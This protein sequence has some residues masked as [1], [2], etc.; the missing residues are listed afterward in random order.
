MKGTIDTPNKQA[1]TRSHRHK[2]PTITPQ[3]LALVSWFRNLPHAAQLAL[4]EKAKQPK[5]PVG[6]AGLEQ[7][8]VE[9]G[10]ELQRKGLAVNSQRLYLTDLATF[11]RFLT[12][13]ERDVTE[14][15][16]PL[17]QQYCAYLTDR[18]Y[19]RASVSRQLTALHGFVM[20]LRREGVLDMAQIP[21]P[22]MFI[23]KV[24][25]SI[26][27]HLNM[28]E[29]NRLIEAPDNITPYGIRDRAILEF[30][31]GAGVRVSELV[32]LDIGDL[33]LHC[34]LS[35]ARPE[36][37]QGRDT[38]ALFLSR[39]GDRITVRTVEKLVQG[40]ARQVNIDRRVYPHLLR[41]SFATHLLEGDASIPAIKEFLGHVSLNTTQRYAHVS[42][43]E[44]RK[45]LMQH[46]P[47]A[48]G[49]TV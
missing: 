21:P 17:L 49:E 36:L 4:Q 31:Y 22:R 11:A 20:Y 19:A 34:Y 8:M 6:P 33:E 18:G 14:M 24:P 48:E 46:H 13:E 2:S 29:V 40:Y 5:E 3:E 1:A 26:P 35:E 32:G 44:A 42:T 37:A 10:R 39:N 47:K 43:I 12:K 15:G 41:H 16:M 38:P 30:L 25:K 45:S 23:T 7:L 9:Y 28:D 27:E